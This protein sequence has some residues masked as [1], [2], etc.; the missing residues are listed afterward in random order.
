MIEN[1]NKEFKLLY[2]D[3]ETIELKINI[4]AKEIYGTKSVK[5][6]ELA[7]E[8]LN[9]INELGYDTLPVCMAKAPN[10]LSDNPRIIRKT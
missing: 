2:K 5:F 6:T 7:K 1:T 8:K 3:E 10:S 4:I 9:L